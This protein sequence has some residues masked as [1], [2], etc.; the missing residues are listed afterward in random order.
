MGGGEKATPIGRAA[1][2]G[3][4]VNKLFANDIG[5]VRR[6]SRAAPPRRRFHGYFLRFRHWF[7]SP[8]TYSSF[9]LSFYLINIQNIDYFTTKL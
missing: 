5:H 2:D 4:S 7:Q 3:E 9:P 1:D 6:A 8:R